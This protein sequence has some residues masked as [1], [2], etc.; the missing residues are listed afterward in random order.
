[1]SDATQRISED[2]LTLARLALSDRAQDVTLFLSRIARRHRERDPE[3][4]AALTGLVR[5]A[6]G[7]SSAL[8]RETGV[9]VPVDADSRLHLLR[10][11][12]HVEALPPV[13]S[14]EVDA[15]IG[16]LI[17]ERRSLERLLAS[18]LVPTR[19]ALFVGPPGVGKTMSARWIANQ[20]GL[21]L[22]T[23]DLSA[24]MSSFLG[25][26]GNNVRAVLDFAKQQPCVLLLDEL[27]A[28]AKRRDDATEVGELKRLVTV[29]LQE[30]DEWPATGLLLAATN[31]PELL[32]PAVWRRFDA[33]VEFPK[34]TQEKIASAVAQFLVDETVSAEWIAVLS[35]LFSENNYSDI[36]RRI[37]QIRRASVLDERPLDEEIRRFVA[38]RVR[39]LTHQELL[40]LAD[41]LSAVPTVSQ[42]AASDIT[43]VSRMTIRKR[44]REEGRAR[45]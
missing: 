13:Y 8:R 33:L 41:K 21:P 45:G 3:G 10:V 40:V 16:A 14:P 24:V 20:L 26:T 30:I 44:Q 27:D 28:I 2:F 6:T 9:P 19:S 12:N 43:G 32:D 17:R 37:D 35:I 36:Q 31:H 11:E 4:C 1:M 22:L 25:R 34:P 7:R 29:L 39:G 23:L 38:E 42:R 5:S 15:Q 18:G